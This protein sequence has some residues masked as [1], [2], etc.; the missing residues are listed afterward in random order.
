MLGK[1]T[2]ITVLWYC[3]DWLEFP[4]SSDSPASVSSV[5]GTIGR[6]LDFSLIFHLVCVSLMA[7]LSLERGPGSILDRLAYLDKVPEQLSAT[8][9]DVGSMR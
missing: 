9:S 7:A 1:H 3:L 5:S 6:Y 8:G 2:V 4:S